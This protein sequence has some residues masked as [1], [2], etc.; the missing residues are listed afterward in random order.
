MQLKWVTSDR[1]TKA[2]YESL[3]QRNNSNSDCNTTKLNDS[4]E[5]KIFTMLWIAFI[6]SDTN[7]NGARLNVILIYLKN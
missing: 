3:R 2:Q 1:I 7:K 6:L 5:L 4:I